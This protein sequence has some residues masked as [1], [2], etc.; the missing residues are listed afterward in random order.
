MKY[1]QLIWIMLVSLGMSINLHGQDAEVVRAYENGGYLVVIDG[2]TLL[3]ITEEVERNLL[4][5]QA[6]LESFQKRVAMQDSLIEAYHKTIDQYETTLNDLKTY[7]EELE[8]I[9]SD[10]QELLA[11]YKKIKTPLITMD[12]GVGLTGSEMKP[13]FMPGIAW[14]NYHL[15]TLVQKN[16]F[17]ILVG[18][19][20]RI[21]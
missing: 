10:Y 3:A 5:R 13:A 17:G 6:E 9:K 20:F 14:R 2:D 7:T 8:G 4:K 1:Q 21:W 16:N 15:W 18:T 12:A 19:T 11:K